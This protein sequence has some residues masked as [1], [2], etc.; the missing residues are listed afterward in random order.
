MSERERERERERKRREREKE[1]RELERGKLL[2]SHL[3]DSQKGEK[4]NHFPP[5]PFPHALTPPP[6]VDVLT[7]ATSRRKAVKKKPM[8]E[9]ASAQGE[10]PTPKASF[11]PR[12]RWEPEEGEESEEVEASLPSSF[13]M[14][15]ARS[16]LFLFE[17]PCPRR[18]N[19]KQSV[20]A[21]KGMNKEGKKR[22]WMR[23]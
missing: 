21:V 11:V 18:E 14:S 4:Q 10:A 6:D 2:K 13:A 5:Y 15:G 19:K 23:K 17:S 16:S 9:F 3:H 20:Y 12:E 1:G 22:V 8:T 7:V